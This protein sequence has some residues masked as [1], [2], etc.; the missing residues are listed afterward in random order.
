M[1]NLAECYDGAGRLDEF[2]SL[3]E[4]TFTL[5]RK[6]NGPECP[7]TLSAMDYLAKAYDETGRLDDAL[8]LREEDLKLHLKVLGPTHPDTLSTMN[9]LACSYDETGRR[10]EALKLREQVLSGRSKAL[11]PAHPDTLAAMNELAR[12]LATSRAAEIRNGTNAVHLAEE[13]VAATQR[14]NAIFLDT[15]ASAYAETQQFEK[16][17]AV[18]Q[19]ATGLLKSNQ[20]KKVFDARLKLYQA[21]KPYRVKTNP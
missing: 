21:N 5:S 11:G 19:E 16:A 4:E 9:D 8:K 18:Q 15:L 7:D 2:R 3:I 12:T 20:E 14:T 17:V 10:D 13:A 1:N 6:V